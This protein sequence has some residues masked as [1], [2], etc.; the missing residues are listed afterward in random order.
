MPVAPR[1]LRLGSGAL[2]MFRPP[3]GP[4][5]GAA[6]PYMASTPLPGTWTTI[7]E[8]TFPGTSLDTTK[9]VDREPWQ[10]DPGYQ[11]ERSWCPLPI[12][13]DQVT[14]GGGQLT[15]KSRRAAGLPNGCT[16]TSAHLSTRGKFATTANAESYIEARLNCP[17]SRGLLPAFWLL[18]NGVGAS[19]WPLT[20]EVDILEFSNNG[21]GEPGSPF[22][23]VWYP[24][25]VYTSPPGT[26]GNATHISSTDSYPKRWGLYDSWHVWGCHR[27]PSRMDFYIDGAL[28]C[29]LL[30]NVAYN[31]NIALPPML[32]TEAMH[33]RLSLGGGGGWAGTAWREVDLEEGDYGV[34]YV[35][36][37]Q[38]TAA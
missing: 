28:W 27:R 33:I 10:T 21:V 23:S 30:P 35:R 15:I 14:V 29:S 24:A 13:T 16:F 38:N 1:I 5:A 37:W 9:W 19:A 11:N 36:C 4:T 26:P 18:G 7:F 8:D 22:T 3:D 32:F 34:D 17:A 31:G 12:T 20:G 2:G 6:T 25:D